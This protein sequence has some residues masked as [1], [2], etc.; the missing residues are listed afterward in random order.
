MLK[1]SQIHVE[2]IN[3]FL[4]GS[5]NISSNYIQ[6]S[7]CLFNLLILV[8][9]DPNLKYRVIISFV[10]TLNL[11]NFFFYAHEESKIFISCF[12]CSL[13]A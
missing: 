13:T 9:N 5:A 1:D 12:G 8:K 3:K 7:I 11:N 10:P 6:N 2:K 4:A